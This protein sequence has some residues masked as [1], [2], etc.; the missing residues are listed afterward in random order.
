MV[1]KPSQ[2]TFW[3]Y[4]LAKVLHKS[5]KIETMTRRSLGSNLKT[6]SR[7]HEASWYFVHS[8]CEVSDHSP[9]LDFWKCSLSFGLH[10]CLYR[11]S[12]YFAQS[13]CRKDE[14][15]HCQKVC[16]IWAVFLARYAS[17]MVID[18]YTDEM[19]LGGQSHDSTCLEMEA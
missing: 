15:R 14:C 13:E 17:E 8:K 1:L 19:P 2:Y 6:R 11:I 4:F 5:E 10:V 12:V 9:C 18:F 7:R 3:G 16:N